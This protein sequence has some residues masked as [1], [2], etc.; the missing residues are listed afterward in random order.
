MRKY[1]T[2]QYQ[3]EKKLIKAYR[4]S[5]IIRKKLNSQLV[6]LKTPFQKGWKV[7]FVPNILNRGNLYELCEEQVTKYCKDLSF[8]T[9]DV[10]YI[11]HIRKNRN[12]SDFK[13][14]FIIACFES[15]FMSFIYR[16]KE[17]DI[18]SYFKHFNTIYYYP[19]IINNKIYPILR[20]KYF[21]IK[22]KKNMITHCRIIN[23]DMESR[24]AE[25]EPLLNE[26]YHL[27]NKKSMWDK[28]DNERTLNIKYQKKTW[29]KLK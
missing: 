26:Y 5:K 21:N 9:K 2:K 22:I 23:P 17:I 15:N 1:F 27:N 8:K 16:Y 10:K 13:E 28:I 29:K 20:S 24:L 18:D 14:K 11:R 3:K 6:E 4:E 12:D 7:E 19:A 25:L